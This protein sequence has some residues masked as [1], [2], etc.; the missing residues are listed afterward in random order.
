M[1]LYDRIV[2]PRIIDLVCGLKPM[3]KQRAKVV[4]FARKRVL[5]LGFGSGLNLPYYDE[6]RVQHVW[7]LEPS[8]AMWNLA[9]ERVSAAGFPVEHLEAPAEAIPLSDAS[10]DTVLVTYT[11]C[12]LPDVAAALAEVR[13]VLKP[14]GQLVFCEH[15]SAPD[16]GVARWQNRVNPIWR[17][18]GGGCNLNRPI[19]SLIQAAGFQVQELS[20][21][22]IPGWRPASFNYWGTALNGT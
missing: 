16:P 11:I 1:G 14:R 7:A 20:S 17:K 21:M 22:Y 3:A 19:P 9:A 15:G 8:M 4:P 10:A 2:L 18:L 12:T 13:R 5:E 6:A